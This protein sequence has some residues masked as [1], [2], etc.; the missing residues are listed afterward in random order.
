MLLSFGFRLAL[1]LNT[2]LRDCVNL[3]SVFV[4]LNHLIGIEL[5]S[6][7]LVFYLLPGCL[8]KDVTGTSRNLLSPLFEYRFLH[9][10]SVLRRDRLT[11]FFSRAF[12]CDHTVCLSKDVTGH[13]SFFCTA[14]P[15]SLSLSDFFVSLVFIASF[16]DFSCAHTVCLSKDVT[17]YCSFYCIAIPRPLILPDSFGFS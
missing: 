13:C 9:R 11:F 2:W 1:R 15:S 12:I 16:L 6:Q 17:G 5:R 3:R 7:G 8:S 4:I 14:L 10:V